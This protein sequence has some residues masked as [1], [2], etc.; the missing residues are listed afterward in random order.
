MIIFFNSINLNIDGVTPDEKVI[1]KSRLK[2]QLD[3]SSKVRTKDVA[4]VL[5]YIDKPPAFDTA[6]A[7]QSADNMQVSMVNLGYYNAKSG[8][9]IQ[10]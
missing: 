9:Q 10:D 4:F 3:D 7:R 5:H 2:T 6:A 1:I 8:L